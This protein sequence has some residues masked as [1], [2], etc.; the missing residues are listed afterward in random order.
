MTEEIGKEK[1]KISNLENIDIDAIKEAISEYIKMNDAEKKQRGFGTGRDYFFY[2]KK[3]R[4]SVKPIMGLAYE[5]KNEVKLDYI[6][7]HSTKK[8]IRIFYE[9]IEK[10]D[11]FYI[12]N[13]ENIFLPDND[14]IKYE[15]LINEPDEELVVYSSDYIPIPEEIPEY[16]ENNRITYKRNPQKGKRAIFRANYKCQYNPEHNSFIRKSNGE[17]YMEPHHIIPFSKQKDFENSLDVLANIVCLCSNCHNEI[18]YGV[19]G[20]EIVRTIYQNRKKELEKAGIIINE[21]RLK[22]YYLGKDRK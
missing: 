7:L 3:V 15:N 18:H 19:N 1:F 8:N 21:E 6:T 9:K 17:M 11:D 14:D 5:I 4:F 13:D 22:Q 16:K 10:C 12:V 20:W 2:Y